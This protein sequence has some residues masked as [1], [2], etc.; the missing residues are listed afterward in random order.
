MSFAKPIIANRACIR[1]CRP[2]LVVV[3]LALVAAC[4]TKVSDGRGDFY[5]SPTGDDA[6]PGSSARPFATLEHARDAVRDLKEGGHRDDIRVVLRGGVYRLR[7]TVVFGLEDSATGDQTITYAAYPGERPILSSGVAI[8]G[9]RPADQPLA[10]LPPEAHG[11]VWVA[12][13]PPELPVFNTLY[14]GAERLPRARG[15]GFHPT[16]D[17][18]T[19]EDID[20]FTL[21]FPKGALK[22]WDN[23]EDKEIVIRPN[24]AWVLNILPLASVDSGAGVART[25]VPATYRQVQVRW[26]GDMLKDAGSVWVENALEAL[27]EP[28]EWVLDAANRRLYLWPKGDQPGPD[29]VAP[30]LTEFIR[31]EGQTNYDAAADVPVRNLVF[32]GLTFTHGDR[33]RWESGK[34]GWGLQHDWEMF[35]RPTA[36]LRLRGAE[37]VSVENCHF[38]NSGG[39]AIRMDL[40]A[41]NNRVVDTVI[42]HMGGVG[43]LMAGY[44]PG[45]K[46]VSRRNRIL[47]NHIHHVGE[48]LWHSPA[49]FV[50]QS[51]ENRIANNLIH[52]TPYS[53]IVISGRIHWDRSGAGEASKT[54]RWDEVDEAFAMEF[55]DG[56][57]ER[58][59]WE[60]REKFLHGRNNLIERNNIHHVMEV[61]RDG[62]GVYVSGTGRGN[63]IREN[64]IHH[65]EAETMNAAIRC[66][67]D[68]HF[69]TIER[70]IVFRNRGSGNGIAIKGRNDVI[71]NFIIGLGI[72]H[73]HR[74][75]ISLEESPVA[76]SVIRH[77]VLYATESEA[78]VYF[79]RG[80]FGPDPHLKDT[81]ADYNVYFN[82]TDPR[83]G[84]AHLERERRHGIEQHSIA[85][86]PLFVA[87]L[88]GDFS[89]RPE[90]PALELGV[91]PIDLSVIGL[92][93]K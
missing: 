93:E 49:I 24:Y 73:D 57:P 20:R 54:I 82:S 8:T 51:G 89:F 67:D 70:N 83:W 62:N 5:V 12:H 33:F 66:D 23:P 65:S 75:Y 68:Q 26:V 52:N 19:G 74:G 78:N 56:P 86:D 31:V 14:D 45:A 18:Q 69:T 11:K 35:D 2:F 38:R 15:P 48:I 39:A 30:S 41:R 6:N 7:E 53:G 77:N 92:P 59:D 46:D 43:I 22:E 47:R 80:L 34:T 81:E 91:E 88:E 4:Q 72:D 71:N 79:Q 3:T 9:W 16:K 36:L 40:H 21:A 50:W 10:G 64:Y 61:L 13:V 58:P 87:P 60:V 1:W 90:S 25:A 32:H 42:E 85:E 17:W 28:G 29:I 27:D 55:P 76:G 44:G 37:G 84:A 63:V